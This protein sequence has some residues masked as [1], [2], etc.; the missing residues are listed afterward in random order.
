MKIDSQIPKFLYLTDDLEVR[1]P[2]GCQ[3]SAFPIFT[4]HIIHNT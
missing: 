1:H 2:I 3:T 4:S